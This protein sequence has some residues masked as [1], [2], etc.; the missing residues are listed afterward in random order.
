MEFEDESND[1][2]IDALEQKDI[3]IENFYKKRS[4]AITV[5]NVGE[6]ANLRADHFLVIKNE[7]DKASSGMDFC[8]RCDPFSC[9]CNNDSDDYT[10]TT[11]FA[12]MGKSECKSL[13][14]TDQGKLESMDNADWPV[15]NKDNYQ[16]WKGNM[17]Q[18]LM[19]LNVCHLVYMITP[20]FLNHTR[21]CKRTV[22]L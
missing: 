5:T 17:K 8:S 15:L 11:E 10:E 14:V 13:E 1:N 2:L 16:Q 21:K 18:N 19:N 12:L 7:E 4:Y 22:R 20:T 6:Y 9:L 3:F